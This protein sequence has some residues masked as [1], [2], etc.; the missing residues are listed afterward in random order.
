MVKLILTIVLVLCIDTISKGYC[1]G[2]NANC[3]QVWY[4]CDRVTGCEFQLIE[5]EGYRGGIE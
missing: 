1:V 3:Y 5:F 4:R 2:A